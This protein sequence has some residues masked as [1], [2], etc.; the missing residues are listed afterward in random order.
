M[1]RPT[2]KRE[3]SLK[4]CAPPRC[5][6]NGLLVRIFCQWMS[7]KAVI[8]QRFGHATLDQ[9]GGRV[10]FS[11]VPA[12]RVREV[13]HMLK[14]IHAQENRQ[15]IGRR[16][17]SVLILEIDV[18]ERLTTAIPHDE[19]DCPLTREGKGDVGA[20]FVWTSCN[21]RRAAVLII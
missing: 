3:R 14:A 5:R 7:G 17:P 2:A 16:A 6:S 10:V 11:H 13:S 20:L 21:A 15:Q 19:A 4:I 18:G 9:I 8:G 12:T 1:T